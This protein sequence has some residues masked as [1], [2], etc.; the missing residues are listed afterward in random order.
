M[1]PEG[2]DE[3]SAPPPIDLEKVTLPVRQW[4][5]NAI[6]VRPSSVLR[7]LEREDVRTVIALCLLGLVIVLAVG[8]P[9]ALFLRW[10]NTTELR[11]LLT[12]I[13][14][15]VLGVFGTVTGFYFGVRSKPKPRG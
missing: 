10:I 15:P 2:D 5:L 4:S 7:R 1:A 14:T 13:W 3:A 8:L 6:Q 9:I 12:G 11:D